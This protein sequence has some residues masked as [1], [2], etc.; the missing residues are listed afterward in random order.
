M[1]QVKYIKKFYLCYY[2]LH[3]PQ[4]ERSINNKLTETKQTKN[5]FWQG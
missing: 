1:L 5:H 4:I 2:L 3:M